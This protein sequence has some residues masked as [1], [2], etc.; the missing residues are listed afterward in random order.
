MF[1][2]SDPSDG[3]HFGGRPTVLDEEKRRKIIAMLANGSSRRMAAAYAGCAHST[4]ART[5]CRDPQFAAAVA[6]AEKNTEIEALHRIRK[7]SRNERYWRAAAWLLERRNPQDFA[8]RP[9]HA[10]TDQQLVQL[11]LKAISPF[12]ETMSD[13]D[14]DRALE[15]LNRMF[16]RIR[17]DPQEAD[18]PY[19]RPLPTPVWNYQ[20]AP[21]ANG[22]SFAPDHPNDLCHSDEAE[23]PQ[24][25]VVEAVQIVPHPPSETAA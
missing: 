18:V 22:G 10:F 21:L 1:G 9:P 19:S 20:T 12:V 11:F 3:P 7:A 8:Q 13:D 23:S 4:L 24:V 14:F 2:P 15:R 6:D 17:L 5:I 25:Y 16:G